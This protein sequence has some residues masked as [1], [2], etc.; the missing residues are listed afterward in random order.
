MSACQRRALNPFHYRE[1]TF[2]MVTSQEIA[3][4]CLPLG[5]FAVQ[6]CRMII[7]ARPALLEFLVLASRAQNFLHCQYQG[8]IKSE[9]LS[10][11]E[12]YTSFAL[13]R[14][15]V[16][17]LWYRLPTRNQHKRAMR[18]PTRRWTAWSIADAGEIT[19]GSTQEPGL[20]H[21]SP[22]AR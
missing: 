17:S 6:V 2:D 14:V 13:Q 20:C 5:I 10:S 18:P 8:Q 19:P 9:L 21:N 15:S 22:E 11:V 7:H 3:L 1:I 12:A 16:T 4:V